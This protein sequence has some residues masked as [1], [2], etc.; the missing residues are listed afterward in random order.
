VQTAFD[1]I[2]RARCSCCTIHQLCGLDDCGIGVL[3]G[4][5]VG[6]SGL[7][8][9]LIIGNRPKC[10]GTEA[11]THP[12]RPS[13]LIRSSVGRVAKV[14][15]GARFSPRVS[16]PSPRPRGRAEPTL[17]TLRWR[18]RASRVRRASRPRPRLR[19]RLLHES[20]TRAAVSGLPPF[21]SHADIFRAAS[22]EAA[23]RPESRPLAPLLWLRSSGSA[24]LAPL[25]WL[26]SS[27]SAPLAQLLWLRFSGSLTTGNHALAFDW[28]DLEVRYLRAPAAFFSE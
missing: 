19:L 27:G 25:L 15:S 8:I 13:A 16:G 22:R 2:K 28:V 9:L 1:I 5:G 14:G 12:S 20:G 3:I 24:P 10:R 11:K 7:V 18:R 26:R 23:A 21:L 4:S 6:E 17:A